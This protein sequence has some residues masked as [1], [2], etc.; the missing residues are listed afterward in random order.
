MQDSAGNEIL[1]AQL[2]IN[3]LT[4]EM[5]LHPDQIWVEDQT[6]KIP[7][8]KGLFLTV[9]MADDRPISNTTYMESQTVDAVTTQ[10]EIN[11]V[12]A[13]EDMQIDIFSRSN[14]ATFRR[15]EIIMALQSIYAQQIQEL[16]NFKIFKIPRSFV[17]T[18]AAEGGS[19][20][21][22]YTITVPCFVWYIKDKVL[23]TPLGD[24]YDDFT[25]RV[26]DENTIG[27]NTPLIEFEITPDSPPPL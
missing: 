8:G 17:K 14:E 27:T 11:K 9:G 16:Y 18:S 3:I 24:Y 5:Q 15:M 26:D 25:T 19:N 23:A 21:N 4:Q 6:R 20:L 1:T 12:I 22:R 10:H 7:D 13:S 2:I